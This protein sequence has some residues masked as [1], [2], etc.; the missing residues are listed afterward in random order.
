MSDIQRYDIEMGWEETA[1]DSVECAQMRP[2]VTGDYV[3]Y[4]DHVA[5]MEWAREVKTQE[6]M[7]A[8]RKGRRD[9]VKAARDAVLP[10]Y[11][12]FKD[13]SWAEEPEIAHWSDAL[14]EVL[15][16]IDALGSFDDDPDT[17]WEKP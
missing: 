9:G 1:S 7:H 16:A 11:K 4:A 10:L 17:H 3:S 15:S 8:Y 6:S 5:A 12:K 14:D 13:A 2:D